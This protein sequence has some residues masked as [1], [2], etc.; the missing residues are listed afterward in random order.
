MALQEDWRWCGICEG[1]VYKGFGDGVCFDGNP[2]QLGNSGAYGVG[3]DEPPPQGVQENWLWCARCQ[4]LF[5]AGADERCFN[6]EPHDPNGSRPYW[7]RLDDVPPGAQDNWRWCNRCGRLIYNGFG[8]GICW[9]GDQHDLSQS[10]AYSVDMFVPPAARLP[11][12]A[13]TVVEHGNLI[14]VSGTQFTAQGAVAIAFVRG[15]EVKK[16]SVVADPDGAFGHVERNARPSSA[17]G[18][19]I[20]RDESTPRF[21]VA[22]LQ[23]LFPWPP[24]GPVLIDSGTALEPE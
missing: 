7:V 6:D 17:T 23:R 24:D 9:D 10:G 14:E 11:Q 19:V 22:S 13:I 4:G 3:F 1:L 12:P 20:A 2:H 5:F 8:D 18:I 21:A 16:V 15:S